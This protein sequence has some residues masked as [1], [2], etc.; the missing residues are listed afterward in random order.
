M[1]TGKKRL[2]IVED[3][4]VY[5]YVMESI[6]NRSEEYK[7]YTFSSG[8]DCVEM[9]PN[10]PDLVILDHQLEKGFSGTDT[11][12]RIRQYNKKIPVIVVSGQPDPLVAQELL[13][14]GAFDYIEK[15]NS[16][17]VIEKLTDS[18]KKALK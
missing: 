12:K 14:M 16:K 3:D 4:S 13:E 15:G 6:L 5:S 2:F 10:N 7:I 8:E 18:I 9:L 17:E 11:L 1:P